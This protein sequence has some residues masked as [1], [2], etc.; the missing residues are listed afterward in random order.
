[1]RRNFLT[2]FSL[3]GFLIVVAEVANGQSLF[4]QGKTITVIAGTEPGGTLDMRIKSLT[5]FIKKYV[6]GGPRLSRN[7]CLARGDER[8][9]T[10]FTG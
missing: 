6:P 1:M 9:P 3:G 2:A 8:Q 7:T 4:Y 5:H 10:I